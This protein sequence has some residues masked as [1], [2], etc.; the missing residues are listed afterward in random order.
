MSAARFAVP[1]CACRVPPLPPRRLDLFASDTN[2][3]WSPLIS[4]DAIYYC[5]ADTVQY[6]RSL[7]GD[8]YLTEYEKKSAGA[9]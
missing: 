5:Q 6:L 8:G 2:L 1:P 9:A 7:G 4:T 3:P